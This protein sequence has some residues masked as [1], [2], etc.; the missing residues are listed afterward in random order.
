MDRNELKR[1]LKNKIGNLTNLGKAAQTMIGPKIKPDLSGEKIIL[2][3][4]RSKKL[5]GLNSGDRVITTSGIPDYIEDEDVVVG[6][7]EKIRENTEEKEKENQSNLV[8]ETSDKKLRIIP[9]VLLATAVLGLGLKGCESDKTVYVP[10]VTPINYHLY[11]TDNPVISATA[12]NAQAVQEGSFNNAR[13]GESPFHGSFYDSNTGFQ[14]ETIA[15]QDGKTYDELEGDMRSESKK[16]TNNLDGLDAMITDI[17]E[18]HDI[19]ESK[20]DLV[21]DSE[22]NFISNTQVYPDSNTQIEIEAAEIVKNSFLEN[23][24]KLE[25]NKEVVQNLDELRNQPNTTVTI[26]SVEEDPIDHDI[27][28]TG[29]SIEMVAKTRKETGLKAAFSRLKEFISNLKNK[30]IDKSNKDDLSK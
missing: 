30:S 6:W 2:G 5:G 9:V 19:L 16:L 17:E 25:H 1:K 15:A 4:S 24:N 26:E 13:S 29:K 28:I 3:E 14:N 22:Q 12:E 10:V 20:K 18:M 23:E 21:I 7:V 27:T 11:D 8:E